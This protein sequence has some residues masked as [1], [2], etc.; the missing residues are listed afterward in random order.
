MRSHEGD[1]F[2][3]S[4]PLVTRVP[5]ARLDPGADRFLRG[6]RASP[7]RREL[8]GT[9]VLHRRNGAS[10][11]PS[12]GNDFDDWKMQSLFKLDDWKTHTTQRR[13]S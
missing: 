9:C 6:S 2:L 12:P 1:D 13:K 3:P 8:A 5:V 10:Y 7:R 11:G 4:R